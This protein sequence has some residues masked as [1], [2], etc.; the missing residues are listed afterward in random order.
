MLDLVVAGCGVIT[1]WAQSV[2]KVESG[3]RKAER[4]LKKRNK[5]Y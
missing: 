5:A 4:I 3:K 2:E 1:Q